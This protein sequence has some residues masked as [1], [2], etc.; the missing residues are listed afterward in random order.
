MALGASNRSIHQSDASRKTHATWPGVTFEEFAIGQPGDSDDLVAGHGQHRTAERSRGGSCR[1][2]FHEQRLRFGNRLL[3]ICEMPEFTRCSSQGCGR[4][5]ELEPGAS[6]Q[7]T[8][9]ARHGCLP[10]GDAR[11]TQP[12]KVGSTFRDCLS[13][14]GTAESLRT[15]Y[16]WINVSRLFGTYGLLNH[17]HPSFQGWAIL[18]R[19]SGDEI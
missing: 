3:S 8:S 16:L 18:V 7:R 17:R 4:L 10:K 2:G 5:R 15:F 6:L 12:L 14:E 1:N 9:E 13:P 19:P 11:I